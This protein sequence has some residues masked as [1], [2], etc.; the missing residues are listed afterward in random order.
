VPVFDPQLGRSHPLSA[1][2]SSPSDTIRYGIIG[3]GLMGVEHIKNIMALPDAEVAAI[4]DPHQPSV[5]QGLEA[6]QASH[7]GSRVK[8]FDDYRNMLE[9]DS[10]DVVV[11]A[12]PN[13]THLQVVLD[14]LETDLPALVEKPLCTNTADCLTVMEAAANRDS[15]LWTGLEYRFMRPIARLIE[16][17][18]E[19][20]TGPVKM[21]AMRE[22]RFPFL[23]KVGDWNR[24]SRN[25][26]GT[27][28]EKCCHFFDLMNL[29]AKSPPVRVMATGEQSVNHLDEIYDGERSDILD[30][31]FVLVDYENGVR[32]MLDLCMFAEATHNQEEVSV[33]GD[34][35]KVEAL[36]PDN[37][38]RIGVRGRHSI[39]NVE[40][41][42]ISLADEDIGYLGHHWGSSYVEHT[43]FLNAVR[44]DTPPD[45]SLHDAMVSV[46]VGEAA[47]LSIEL[48]RPVQLDEIIKTG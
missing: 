30:N 4:A 11:V 22:H 41:E 23:P 2:S 45:I 26:G 43:R 31:A 12:T 17:V 21:I 33:V 27:L 35:G 40:A 46:A 32:A 3:A 37:L 15:M 14:V 34:R 28:V 9:S 7:L 42:P 20:V 47:H 39:G 19:G 36:I 48:G 29:L 16:L 25:T 5:D 24:F 44:T 1:T 18:D 6:I 10:C 8:V 13:M 38:V